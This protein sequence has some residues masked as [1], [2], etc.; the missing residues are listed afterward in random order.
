MPSHAYSETNSLTCTWSR[1]T[2]S[3]PNCQRGPETGEWAHCRFLCEPQCRG[4]SD[5]CGYRVT[6]C[7]QER[8]LAASSGGRPSGRLGV[9]GDGCRATNRDIRGP[10]LQCD[11]VTFHWTFEAG[12]R[13]GCRAD[14]DSTPCHPLAV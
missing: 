1:L 4:E 10:V 7:V 8:P 11:P 13:R 12:T 2:D 3:V 9:V 6:R 5:S 14:A